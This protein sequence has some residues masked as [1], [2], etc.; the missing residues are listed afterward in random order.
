MAFDVLD[1][2]EQGELVQKWLR[3]N[4]MSMVQSRLRAVAKAI[5]GITS[6]CETPRAAHKCASSLPK[7]S[8]SACT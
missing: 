1:E 6:A 2:H 5:S 7:S 4:A 3:E 8:A